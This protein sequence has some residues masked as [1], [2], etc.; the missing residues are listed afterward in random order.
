MRGTIKVWFDDRGYGWI[1]PHAQ[2]HDLFAHAHDLTGIPCVGATV[3]FTPHEAKE[4]KKARRPY[5]TDIKV[6]RDVPGEDQL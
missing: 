6:V 2:P 1:K 3:D 5:A 4:N